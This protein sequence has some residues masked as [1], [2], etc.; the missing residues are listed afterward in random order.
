MRNNNDLF[1]YTLR[2]LEKKGQLELSLHFQHQRMI[3]T[4]NQKAELEKLKQEIV[5]EVLSRI[6]IMFETGEAIKKIDALNKAI[7]QLER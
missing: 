1:T 5:E 3:E 7:Q 4:L 6:S 2:E